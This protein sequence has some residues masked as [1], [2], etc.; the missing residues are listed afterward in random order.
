MHKLI[1]AFALFISTTCQA[2]LSI[3]SLVDPDSIDPEMSQVMYTIN[4]QDIKVQQY[5]NG[6][7]S[8]FY[9]KLCNTCRVKVYQLVN[10]APLLLNERAIKIED[11]AISLIKKGFRTVQLGIDRTSGTIS[12]LYLGGVNELNSKPLAQE[13]QHEI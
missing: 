4:T 5:N 8:S 2:E 9:L 1:I 3:N 6:V 10:N 7:P 13:K 12:Y 11:L